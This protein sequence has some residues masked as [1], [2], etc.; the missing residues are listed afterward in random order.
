MAQT[1]GEEEARRQHL[2]A[3]F[4]KKEKLDRTNKKLIARNSA[5]T[6]DRTWRPALLGST[7]LQNPGAFVLGTDT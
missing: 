6:I 1:R 5:V 7:A 4:H 2:T 3:G